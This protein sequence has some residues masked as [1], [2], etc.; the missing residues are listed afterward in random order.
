MKLKLKELKPMLISLSKCGGLTGQTVRFSLACARNFKA[1]VPEDKTAEEQR[2]AICTKYCLK[3][4]DGKPILRA[5]TDDEGRPTELFT[6]EDEGEVNRQ[7]A[8]LFDQEIDIK[9]MTIKESDLPK[10]ITPVQVTGL[11]PFI[12]EAKTPKKK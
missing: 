5:G 6:F 8:D 9:L 4:E 12:T 3:D 2:E 7:V 1:V 10:N 11:L